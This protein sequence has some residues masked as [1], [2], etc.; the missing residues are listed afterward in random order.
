MNP[1]WAEKDFYE[2]LG[3]DKTA[4]A[5]EIKRA[6]RKL[7]QK[8][9]PDANPDDPTAE[10][11]F[12]D[13]SEAYSILSSA[14][15]RKDYDEFRRVVASGGYPG[16]GFGGFGTAG[17]P[18]GGQNIRVEDLSDL[19]GG[20]GDLF[21]GG[22]ARSRGTGPRRGAD[23]QADLHLSFEDA[24][25]G[26]TTTVTVRGEAACSRCHGSG[27]EPGTSVTSCPTCGGT[28]QV[29]QNQGL[30]SFASPCQECRGSGRRIDQ[31]CT[32]CR[33]R[34]TEIRSRNIKVKIPAGV[35]DGGT[36]RLRG[37][38]S[39]GSNGGPAGDLLV[40]VHVS[41]HGVFSRK[42]N[43]LL[44]TIPVTFAEA[45]LG[46]KI[47][48][49]TMNGSVKLK[50]PA[51]TP[52]GKTFRV[53]GKGV[54]PSRGKAGDLLARVEVVIPKRMS[55]DEKRL[56]EQLATYDDDSIRSHLEV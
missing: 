53:R 9:H 48:V 23:L 13:V 31:P 4:S 6:Y 56:V 32:S 22:A 7:A 33:G 35:K 42:G 44:V 47:D 54:V 24:V 8:L 26:V 51:G 50:I 1:D 39:P 28:G 17:G 38:G 55:K 27:A 37:N 40:K 46:T 52:S 49:P 14:E 41:K 15:K 43:D 25:H 16:A 21:G 10:E 12:K 18:F 29:A 20:F 34:G 36:I 19:F 45:S 11:R 3:V 30:F 5:E 2:I